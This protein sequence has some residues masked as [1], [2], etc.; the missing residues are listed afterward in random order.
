MRY[1]RHMTKKS[2]EQFYGTATV[3]EKGQVV[4]P[5]EAREAMGLEKG[6]RLLVFGMGCDMI[7]L[8][9]LSNVE[10]IASRLSSRLDVIRE[11]IKNSK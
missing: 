6:D 10:K 1:H 2:C 8:S 9:K 3:S 5:S 4:I 11:V 7:A